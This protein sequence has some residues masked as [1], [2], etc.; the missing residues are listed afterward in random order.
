MT[1]F[2]NNNEALRSLA[3]AAAALM[4]SAMFLVAAAGPAV[5]APHSFNNSVNSIP[6][7]NIVRGE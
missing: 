4:I 5:A 1:N 3:S 6:N 2:F 7:S